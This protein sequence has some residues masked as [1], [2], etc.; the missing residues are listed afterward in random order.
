MKKELRKNA[1]YDFEKYFFKLKSNA[2]F[3]KVMDILRK[4]TDN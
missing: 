3:K 1:L 4:H 2:G